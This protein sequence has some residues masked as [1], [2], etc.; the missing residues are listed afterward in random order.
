LVYEKAL[1]API[2]ARSAVTLLIVNC[3]LLD[4][5]KG[6]GRRGCFVVSSPTSH[7]S[8]RRAIFNNCAAIEDLYESGPQNTSCS[9]PNSIARVISRLRVAPWGGFRLRNSESRHAYSR[10]VSNSRAPYSYQ[11]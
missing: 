10:I 8:E 3:I 2:V 7:Q 5:E 4:T 11:P 1:A 6:S 9:L